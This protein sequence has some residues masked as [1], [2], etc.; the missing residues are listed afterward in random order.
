[1]SRRGRTRTQDSSAPDKCRP[2]G[3]KKLGTGRNAR[4]TG[5]C[6]VAQPYAP[7]HG[8]YYER[9]LKPAIKRTGLQPI[10]ADVDLTGAG[11]VIDQ[12]REEIQAASVLVID[13]ST[14]NPNVYYE[15]GLAHAWNKPVVLIISST[16]P[17]IPFDVQ[18]IRVIRYDVTNPFWGIKLKDEVT[19]NVVS[20]LNNYN[21]PTFK[22]DAHGR[23]K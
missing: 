9:I 4:F 2:H 20:A 7:P 12:V 14:R 15:L 22:A 23:R 5:T 18:H 11:P 6:F 16:E 3:I 8:E 13:L 17:S 21:Q 1:M 19:E 10:R